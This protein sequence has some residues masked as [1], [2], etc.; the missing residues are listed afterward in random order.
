MD[1]TIPFINLDETEDISVSHDEYQKLQP[2][3]T[4]AIVLF[5]NGR[6]GIAWK[7]SSRVVIT[8]NK[9]APLAGYLTRFESEFQDADYLTG[10]AYFKGTDRP[11]DDTQAVIHFQRAAQRGN[12]IAQHDLAYMYFNGLG[13]AVQ[14][15][16]AFELIKQSA[17]NGYALAQDYL[18]VMYGD[19]KDGAPQDWLQSYYW[20][21]KAA[22]QGYPQAI[23][24]MQY[25]R[26]HMTPRQREEAERN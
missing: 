16:A 1:G 3:Q 22:Q 17:Q 18:G 2:G 26:S 4:K 10:V 12:A 9:P 15:A 23:Q 14:T 21:N 19:G 8:P 24:D 11:K 20:I 7:L 13:T 6:Y 5:K 25:V